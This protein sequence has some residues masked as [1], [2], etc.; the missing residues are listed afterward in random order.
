MVD[1]ENSYR[2][3]A[4]PP[5]GRPPADH[6]HRVAVW[7]HLAARP[8][9]E[10]LDASSQVELLRARPGEMQQL[11]AGDIAEV[12]M[13]GP[14]ELQRFKR[15]LVI[16]PAGCIASRGPTSLVR[17]FSHVRPDRV[18]V[19]WVASG[20]PSARGLAEVLWSVAYGRHLRV[21]PFAGPASQAPADA[22]AVLV[23]GDRVMAD[24][25]IGFDY[26]IDLGAMWHRHTGLPFV[27]AV[28]AGTELAH[29][30]LLNGLL[31]DARKR[32]QAH[33]AE[34]AAHFGP[35]YGWPEDLAARELTEH[36]SYGL[37]AAEIDGLEEFFDLAQTVGIIDSA[38]TIHV[39]RP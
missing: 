23:A 9:I 15:P 32:G 5:T 17:M 2:E 22:E 3:G 4:T 20:D 13:L 33:A 18:R 37:T 12:A 34:I 28:W 21:I 35:A 19:A 25:P 11:L 30:E 38:P 1:S 16:L 8:L 39:A 10:G 6:R 36:L 31:A 24:P 14:V 26:Q 7:P 29:L 27:H